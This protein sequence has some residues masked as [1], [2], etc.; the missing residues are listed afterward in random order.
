[1][2]YVTNPGSNII[3]VI[4]GKTNS[5]IVG[6]NFNIN[7]LGSGNI[8][9]NGQKIETNYS[10]YNIGT[11]LTCEADGIS[12]YSFSSWSKGNLS[13]SSSNP[14]KFIANEYGSFTVSFS[15]LLS[16]GEYTSIV[17]AYLALLA[18]I[19]T[20]ISLITLIHKRR[21]KE[22][23][24]KK[25]Q[26]IDNLDSTH[27]NYLRNL[28]EQKSYIKD[29]LIREKISESQYNI[30]QQRISDLSDNHHGYLKPK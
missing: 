23:F 5:L 27:D 15:R 2:I 30:L 29:L 11:E 3:S 14:L 4:D 25:L 7:P 20:I 16:L 10:K 1:M 24:N 17:V 28:E 8:Y 6:V 18:P 9:C 13:T 19:S 12:G 22:L 21:Q 26:T